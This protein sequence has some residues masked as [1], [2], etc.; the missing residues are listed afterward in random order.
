MEQLAMAF[1][2]IDPMTGRR[3]KS[4]GRIAGVSRNKSTVRREEAEIAVNDALIALGKDPLT[5]RKLLSIVLNDPNSTLEIRLQCAALLA[6]YETQPAEGGKEV[7][8]IMP[9]QIPG[10]TEHQRLAVW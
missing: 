2:E 9:P 1:K 8:T 10:E 7:V 5:G 4:G 3:K 6:R